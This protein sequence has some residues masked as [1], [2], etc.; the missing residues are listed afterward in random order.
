MTLLALFT[1]ILGQIHCLV[2]NQRNV[3]LKPDK[4]IVEYKINKRAFGFQAQATINVTVTCEEDLRNSSTEGKSLVL[5]RC[6]TSVHELEAVHY[7]TNCPKVIGWSRSSKTISFY[8]VVA[9]DEFS[10]LILKEQDYER[11]PS[12]KI[13]S[14]QATL[15]NRGGSHLSTDQIPIPTNYIVTLVVWMVLSFLWLVNS[16]CFRRHSNNL[17]KL[18]SALLIIKLVNLILAYIFW[19]ELDGK[20]RWSLQISLP[21][22]LCTSVFE[23]MIFIVLMLAGE[24]WCIIWENPRLLKYYL[25]LSTSFFFMVI[26][27]KYVHKYFQGFAIVFASMMIYIAFKCTTISIN[28]VKRNIIA[29]NQFIDN[30]RLTYKSEIT[31][32][33]R[34][35]KKLRMFNY[36]QGL[37]IG[38]P[39]VLIVV[40]SVA[41]FLLVY[42][43]WTRVL[44]KEML[45]LSVIVYCCTLFRL[46]NFTDYN[47]ISIT[48]PYHNNVVLLTPYRNI[49]YISSEND[50]K[51]GSEPSQT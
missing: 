48:T 50:D 25:V 27:Y 3:K 10:T 4:Q 32:K 43:E 6:P 11:T 47:N 15:L 36:L 16:L 24:G 13:C 42:N 20:G 38:L 30:H 31:L 19:K 44:L 33:K 22:I 14:V 1:V 12:V 8:D 41:S 39:C 35:N 46:R 23:T 51:I 26:C 40:E 9:N 21:F 34:L 18:L 37:I 45:E 29:S 17:H 28:T 7:S 49:V 2:I 5:Y